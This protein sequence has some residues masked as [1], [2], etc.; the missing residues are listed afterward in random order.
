MEIY[1]LRSR[2]ALSLL[3]D[4]EVKTASSADVDEVQVFGRDALSRLSAIFRPFSA[5]STS[6]F[7][8]KD[9]FVSILR[10]L[11]DY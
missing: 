11:Q 9:A 1:W 2:V 4:F 10:D 8:I 6:I 5:A 7:A 3:C